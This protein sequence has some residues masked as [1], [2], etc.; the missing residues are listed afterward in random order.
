[1]EVLAQLMATYPA[2]M[3][4]TDQT[5][6]MAATG[7]LAMDAKSIAP[8]AR[9][10][11]IARRLPE[12][13]WPEAALEIVA[14]DIAA[15]ALVAFDRS[16]GVDLVDA[17][18]ASCAVPGVWPVATIKGRTYTDGGSYSADNAHLAK[19]AERVIIASPLGG[20]S[21]FP[22]GFHLEDQVTALEAAGSAILAICPDDAAREAMGLN[23]LDPAVRRPCALAGRVQ[24]RT[25]AARLSELWG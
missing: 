4:M 14:F 23:P 20:I 17:V 16:S 11:V 7:R 21:P 8:E 2:L 24:G 3:A 12:H 15:G 5:E 13:D 19:G 18:T 6:R 22:P 10:A 25:L 9:R 1:M